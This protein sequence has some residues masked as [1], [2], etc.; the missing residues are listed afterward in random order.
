[1]TI[2]ASQFH[3]VFFEE[4]LEGLDSM[5][6]ELLAAHP[7]QVDAETINA[8]FRVAHTIKGGAATFGFDEIAAFSHK[9]ETLLDQMRAGERQLDDLAIEL[10]L[11]VVDQI[12]SMVDGARSGSSIDSDAVA[13]F[14]HKVEQALNSD[15]PSQSVSEQ[16]P[17]KNSE[18]EPDPTDDAITGWSI[19][20]VPDPS[21]LVH[22][23]DVVLMF[24][25]LAAMGDLE[26]E[27]DLTE[28]PPLSELDVEQCYLSWQLQLHAT[29]EK[30]AVEEVFEWVADESELTIEA[31]GEVGAEVVVTDAVIE[32]QRDEASSVGDSKTK[33][34][35]EQESGKRLAGEHG[36]SIR[37]N[38]DKVDALVNLVGELVITQSMLS[39]LRGSL[40]GGDGDQLEE[41]L[42]QLERHTRNLQDSVL[43]MRM[44]PIAF[45]FNRF[46]RMVRD[47]SANIGKQVSLEIH[48]E[49]TEID[50]TVME[51]IGDP[52]MHLVRNAVDHGLEDPETRMAAGKP[53]QG[54]ISLSAYHQSGNIY[55]EVRDDGRGIDYEK[56][57]ETAR[58]KGLVAADT[59]IEPDAAWHLLFQPGFSTAAVVSDISGRGVGLD[60]VNRN[61]RSL[62]GSINV[63]SEVGQGSAFTIRLP[64]TLAI[65]DGQLIQ[66]GNDVYIIP[67]EAIVETIRLEQKQLSTIADWLELYHLRDEYIPVIHLAQLF[68]R[69]ENETERPLVV[70]VEFE[71]RLVGLAVEQ[72]QHQQQVVIKS[73]ETNFWKVE[74]VSAATILGD[75]TVGL[76]LDIGSLIHMADRERGEIADGR[77]LHTEKRG[78]LL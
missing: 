20:F 21:I 54:S 25:E 48:G 58:S 27:A 26:V 40:S 6:Q 52:L 41:G 43:G 32:E 34:S 18:N 2:D 37:V 74:G 33:A 36:G 76:I 65:L 46:P 56:V 45:V 14:T 39:R 28:L 38:I 59:E 1:M 60:V 17:Q 61:V 73:L 7:G 57:I 12:R 22:G 68:H 67:L 75:G 50:K 24:R 77:M 15:V 5:E 44:L 47:L 64:L 63:S 31:I 11:G 72:L 9:V 4:S 55:V 66:V 3:Q 10:L 62:G 78:L 42:N 35:I 13:L 30:E 16:T 69:K 53:E 23:N 49:A 70:I 19:H 8:I 71:G 51:A 29:V